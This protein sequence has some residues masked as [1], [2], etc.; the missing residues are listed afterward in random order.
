MAAL[1][2][3]EDIQIRNVRKVKVNA[4]V[5][6]AIYVVELFGVIIG[7]L[8]LF[9]DQI[10]IDLINKQAGVFARIFTQQNFNLN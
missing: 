1:S 9:F 6:F 4:Q 7:I 10:V 5:A 2:L 8:W 3:A